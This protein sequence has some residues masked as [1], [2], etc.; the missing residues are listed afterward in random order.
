MRVGDE[1][2]GSPWLQ[3]GGGRRFINFMARET[4]LLKRL[5]TKVTYDYELI[6]SYELSLKLKDSYEL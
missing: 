2:G 6:M 3:M 5:V 1:C 4:Y